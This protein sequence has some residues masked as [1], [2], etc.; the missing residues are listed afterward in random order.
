MK[1]SLVIPAYNEAKRIDPFLRSIVT[2]YA[3][4][5][6]DIREI[7]VVDDGSHD[8]TVKIA[9][10]HSQ[11]LP[12]RIIQHQHNQGKGAAVQTGML[13]ARGDA[14]VFMDAD[15]ATPISELPKMLLA[16]EKAD[17]A[18]GNRWMKGAK[19]E[20]H[21]LLR[22]LSGWTYRTY[23]RLFGL[24]HIDTMCGFKGYRQSVIHKLFTNLIDPGWLFDT[25]IAYKTIIHGYSVI[26]FPIRWTSKDGSKLS[27]RTLIKSAFSIWPLIRQIKKSI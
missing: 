4:H 7:I 17:V 13:A 23:M 2:Y 22:S 8:E 27:T 11:H 18:V 9:Q 20:R 21:S 14:A 24:G 3:R 12:I 5:P 6:K 15:G 1:I 26:N 16:L 25:E 19:T 10:K